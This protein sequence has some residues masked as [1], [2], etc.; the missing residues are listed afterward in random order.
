MPSKK[1][2]KSPPKGGRSKTGPAPER[3][4]LGQGGWQEKVKRALARGKPP[5]EGKPK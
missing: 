5:N 1:V 2:K 3:L 4:A